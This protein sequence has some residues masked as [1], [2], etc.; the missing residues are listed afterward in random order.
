MHVYRHPTLELT[1]ISAYEPLLTTTNTI[2]VMSRFPWIA[3]LNHGEGMKRA[4]LIASRIVGQILSCA[5]ELNPTSYTPQMQIRPIRHTM[6]FVNTRNI[7]STMPSL[8]YRTLSCSQ[9]SSNGTLFS[10][11]LASLS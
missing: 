8:A 4:Y 10:Q 6:T 2:T 1:P 3:L 7:K 11:P 9:V 5:W